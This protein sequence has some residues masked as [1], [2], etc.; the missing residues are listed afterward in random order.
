MFKKDGGEAAVRRT[1]P[2]I[3]GAKSVRAGEMVSRQCLGPRR[4]F[5]TRPP[6]AAGAALPGRYVEPLNDA[7]TKLAAF[8]NILQRRRMP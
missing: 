8:F 5:L 6:R 3:S 4:T 7:R 1:A 2:R